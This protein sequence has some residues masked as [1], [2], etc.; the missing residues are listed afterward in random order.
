MMEIQV[1]FKFAL[2]Y[3]F[4]TNENP[5][6]GAQIFEYLPKSLKYM[7]GLTEEQ[8]KRLQVLRVVP[9]NTEQQLGYVTSVAIATWPKAFFPQLRLDVKTPFSQFYQNT[10]NGMLAHNLT[11]LVNPA[12]D[13]LPGATLDGKPA[14]AGSGTGGN[15]SNGPNDVFN[16]DNNSTNQSATQRG[17]V[18]GIAFGAVSLAA[19]YGAAMFIVARRYKK[20]RQAHRRS[21][22]VATPSEMRQ[23]GSPALM[24]GA[25][26]SRDFTHYGGVM[27]PAGGRESHGS[28]GSG[29]SAGNSAR[30]AGISAPVAQ[31]NSLGWN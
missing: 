19:A 13:I 20:K 30:T 28:N 11:M 23:S 7:E 4:I 31:E 22:S 5:N 1:A 17:T 29:R 18:A 2:N 26:L 8:K 21:S 9:L 12:I 27:G 24:G 15:G 14:G 6:A 10:S 16:N 25:L 3:R